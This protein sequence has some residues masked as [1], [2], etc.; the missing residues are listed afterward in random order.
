MKKKKLVYIGLTADTIHHGHINLIESA[1][2]Y[3]NIIVGLLTDK[4]VKDYKRMPL[5]TF[6]QRKKIL[7]NIKGVSKV[8]KQND[9]DY[10]INIRKYKPDYMVHG[11]DWISGPQLK[12]RQNAI[13]ELK[14]YKGKLIEIPYTKGVSSSALSMEQNK[15]F[16]TPETRLKS[17]IRLIEAKNFIR[18]I[19][20]HNP[21]SALIAE[22]T[23]LKVKNKFKEFDG[24][25]SS[26]L[27]DS[28]SMG[29]PDIEALDISERLSNINN[30][31][32]VTSKPLVMDIDTGGKTEHLKLNIRSM[33]RLGISAVVMEDKTGLKKNSLNEITSNQKQEGLKQFCDKIDQINKVKMNDEF[34]IIARIES[35]I[36]GK[37]MNDAINRAN[38]YVEA[39]ANGIMI[40]SKS[41]KPNEIFQFS[42]IFRKKYPDTP[43]VCVPSTYNSVKE[44]TL[45]NKKFNVVIYANHLFRASYP[46]MQKTAKSILKF[47]RSKELDSKLISIKEIL[48]LIPGT[49]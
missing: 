26:S 10:A 4:A 31:F 46:A 37:G 7:I 15:K 47:G 24:F 16:T 45:I 14:K 38:N 2:E 48:K 40:H 27:T 18:I 17:L 9:W 5:L 3:G 39:G 21:I 42:D 12:L 43:L 44:S 35:L 8:V 32:D 25:W 23:N 34:M 6:D 13:R 1:R 11:S 41:K 30:I 36:L 49:N 33:E 28:T 19:E 22:N 20:A 29:K